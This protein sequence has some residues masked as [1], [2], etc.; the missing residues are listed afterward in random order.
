MIRGTTVYINL[1]PGRDI[2]SRLFRLAESMFL[3][4]GRERVAR[5]CLPQRRFT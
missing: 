1:L 5:R 3:I 4:V 2:K